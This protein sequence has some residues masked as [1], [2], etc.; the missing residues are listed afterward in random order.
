M[1]GCQRY[2]TMGAF[3]IP[4]LKCE[5]LIITRI[6]NW[7]TKTTWL[8]RSPFE[9]RPDSLQAN[10]IYTDTRDSPQDHRNAHSFLATTTTPLTTLPLAHH[11]KTNLTARNFPNLIPK[12][13]ASSALRLMNPANPPK[14]CC[15][16]SRI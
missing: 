15:E 10:L 12:G 5:T 3:P 13:F 9:L 16:T 14:T 7:R 2:S 8:N 6:Q 1:N 4:R 11:P